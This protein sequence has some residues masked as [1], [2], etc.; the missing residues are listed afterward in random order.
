MTRI[1]YSLNDGTHE[2]AIQ[3]HAGYDSEGRDIVC[4]A[5]S[6][7]CYALMGYLTNEGRGWS[8]DIGDGQLRFA[9]GASDRVDTAFDMAL[10][11]LMQIA[12]QY[13]GYVSINSPH[14]ENT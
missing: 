1:D 3:G 4:A 9:A 8:Y 11:G 2:L 12:Q 5:V 14:G 10:I 13:P 7:I 6:S